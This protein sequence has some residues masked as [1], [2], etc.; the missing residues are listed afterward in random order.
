[1]DGTDVGDLFNKGFCTIIPEIIRGVW[2]EIK[3]AND[4]K[5]EEVRFYCFIW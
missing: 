1:M 2:Q 4:A 3:E 5:I